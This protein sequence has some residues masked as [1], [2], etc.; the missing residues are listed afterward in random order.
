MHQLVIEP[1][2]ADL[3]AG[4]A[5]RVWA[6][7]GHTVE[8]KI[9]GPQFEALAAEWVARYAYDEAALTVGAVGQSVVACRDHKAGHEVDVLALARG[10]RPRTPGAP[11]A[12]IGEARYRDRRP[13][14]AELRRLEHIRD[15]L[16]AAGHDASAATFGLFSGAGF[17]ED[18]G[19]EATR[20]D[21]RIRLA[22]LDTLYGL[23]YPL[24]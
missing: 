17:T 5:R 19:A 2:L 18:L 23:R 13:G 14:L 1:Y 3:E 22:G 16:A 9:F 20:S 10:F 21:G 6:E 15:L 12:F 7:S 11:I 8:S 24:P 4:R